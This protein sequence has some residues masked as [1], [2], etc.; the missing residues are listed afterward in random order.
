MGLSNTTM[1]L[2]EVIKNKCELNNIPITEGQ[3]IIIINEIETFI[4]DIEGNLND[5]SGEE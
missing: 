2:G 3:R 1:R 5:W 4:R